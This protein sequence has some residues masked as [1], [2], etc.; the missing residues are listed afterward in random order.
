MHGV[1]L[2]A[3]GNGHSTTLHA[4]FPADPQLQYEDFGILNVLKEDLW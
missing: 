3:G 2:L 4:G 1:G